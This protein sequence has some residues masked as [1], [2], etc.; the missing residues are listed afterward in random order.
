MAD[1]ASWLALALAAPLVAIT[2]AIAYRIGA[3]DGRESLSL[4]LVEDLAAHGLRCE[5]RPPT[6][7]ARRLQREFGLEA[8]EAARIVRRA[9]ARGDAVAT[10]AVR[11]AG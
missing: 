1:G 6:E 9:R 10:V 2:W 4:E 8:G 3:A 5:Q 7:V 11:R